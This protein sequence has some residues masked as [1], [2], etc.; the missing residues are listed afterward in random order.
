MRT[1]VTAALLAVA[2]LAVPVETAGA[3]AACPTPVPIDQLAPG[4][5]ATGL[6]V[7]RGTEPQRFDVEVLGVLTDGLAPGRDVIVVDTAGAAIDAA[8]GVWSG[9]SGSPVYLGEPSEGLLIGAVAY[10]FSS[11]PSSIA[12]LTPAED[13]LEL[14]RDGST[15]PGGGTRTGPA[16]QA[17][18]GLRQ[19]PTPLG[20]SGLSRRSP[21]EL[22]QVADRAGLSVRVTPG[23]TSAVTPAEAPGPVAGGNFAAVLSVGDVTAAA[24]GTT[25]VVCEGRAVA[26]AHE[27]MA[28]GATRLSANSASVIA[29]V[30]DPEDG[31][32]KLA[33]VGPAFGTLDQDR[34]SGVR[35]E[36]G[37][38][39]TMVP[40][41][42][43][44]TAAEH[45]VSRPGESGVIRSADVPLAAGLHLVGNIDSTIDRVGGGSSALDVRVTGWDAAGTAFDYQRSNVFISANDISNETAFT[46]NFE[47][48]TALLA[49]PGGVTFE[50]VTYDA[51]VAL[52]M[53]RYEITEV[54]VGVDGAAPVAVTPEH[55]VVAGPG[56]VLDVVVVLRSSAG[57]PPRVVPLAVEV[58]RDAAAGTLMVQGAR[59]AVPAPLP[60]TGS[61]QALVAALEARP[62]NA[63][64]SA[65]FQPHEGGAASAATGDATVLDK[66]VQGSVA[67]P[68]V[69]EPPAHQ[70][71][72]VIGADRVATAAALSADA[73]DAA[74]TVLI[75]RADGYA[76]ALAAA[77][78][79]STLSAPILLTDTDALRPEVADEIVRLGARTAVLLGG[80]Q[81]LRDEVVAALGARGVET[82]RVAGSDRFSTAGRIA[83]EVGGEAVY[84]AR[85]WPD[86][87][88]VSALAAEQHR[89]ILLVETDRV[90]EPT[91]DALDELGVDDVTIVG[92]PAAVAEAVVDDLSE[93]AEVRRVAGADRY[94]TSLEVTKLAVVGGASPGQVTLAT[95][96]AFP[97]ALAAG[98][99]V[100][101]AGG[102]LLLL[103][104]ETAA[105]SPATYD[106]LAQ[107]RDTLDMVRFLGG[108]AAIAPGVRDAVAD[109]LR[110]PGDIVVPG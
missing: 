23:G 98:P 103:D 61:A 22:Q 99:A 21:D 60:E 5:P 29:V 56:A 37:D 3:Q 11:G 35:A 74:D 77:P 110:I 89:P 78:L 33:N 75:A 8:G 85:D 39:P 55:L 6:T 47:V 44:V 109:V 83:A 48:L 14:L 108:P 20:V 34:W 4:T 52:E 100:A 28:T 80:E 2:L 17:Q 49:V 105:G 50:A 102:V 53:A 19:L 18:S 42:S 38:G 70:V 31:P 67:V 93:D 59:A 26:L 7:V 43:Q 62:T 81:A 58:P 32:F 97:D 95:G 79:A 12:G 92:G 88:S 13:L 30:D 72:E 73:F 9:M 45:G 106:Y 87:L 96:R 25:A 91:R 57:D 90:P 69:V 16:L 68:V 82:R 27:F 63:Q 104:G 76:D 36:V 41:R 15:T 107:I 51:R 24:I 64:L 94:A 66:F 40:V 54:R 86:A 10:G 65:S 84:V 71:R 1:A 46:E 101:A